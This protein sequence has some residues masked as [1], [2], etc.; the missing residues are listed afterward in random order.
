[1]FYLTTVCIQSKS[2]SFSPLLDTKSFHANQAS[3]SFHNK[4][5]VSDSVQ[6]MQSVTSA[7][8]DVYI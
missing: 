1:M 3:Q 7:K 2:N 8:S 4:K 6:R 5:P